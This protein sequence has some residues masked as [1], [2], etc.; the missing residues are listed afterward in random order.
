MVFLI[1]NG[2]N[3]YAGCNR[4]FSTISTI[5]FTVYILIIKNMHNQILL[6]Y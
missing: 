1:T 2:N 4:I 5:I 6:I 3:L